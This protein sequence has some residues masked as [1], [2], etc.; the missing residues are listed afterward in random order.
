MKLKKVTRVSDADYVRVPM[1]VIAHIWD[2][3]MPQTRNW[4]ETGEMHYNKAIE[5]V[6]RL[7]SPE[8]LK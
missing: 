2:M 4:R 3:R 7:I 5:D 8:K 6:L 1:T